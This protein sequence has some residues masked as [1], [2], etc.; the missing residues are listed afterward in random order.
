[1]SRIEVLQTLING[2]LTFPTERPID[3]KIRLESLA[4]IIPLI[5]RDY[6]ES[7]K[8]ADILREDDPNDSFVIDNDEVWELIREG[9][10]L[11]A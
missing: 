2:K 5:K 11:L 4:T 7:Q 3:P 10:K 8:I 9:E 1:M 6:V